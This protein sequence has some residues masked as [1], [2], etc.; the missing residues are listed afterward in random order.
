M[1]F[2][3]CIYFLLCRV[4]VAAYRLSPVVV[5]RLFIVVISLVADNRLQMHR[6][7]QVQHVG[8]A[9]VAPTLKGMGS[10][11]VAHGLSCS[12]VC[13]IFP[14]QELNLCPLH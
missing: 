13:G 2:N 12:T 10:A 11:V 7:P 6:L 5:C 8:S 4:F 1:F 3:N 14:D 9:V